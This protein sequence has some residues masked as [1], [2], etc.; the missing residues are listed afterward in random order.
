MTALL[1][2]CTDGHEQCALALI[3]AGAAAA[4]KGSGAIFAPAS[5]ITTRSNGPSVGSLSLT[6]RERH[7]IHH[8]VE[9]DN[10]SL[11]FL[12]KQPRLTSASLAA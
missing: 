10:E 2:A 1:W 9:G 7:G 6:R 11:A 3:K 12:N 4:P 8:H 5:G